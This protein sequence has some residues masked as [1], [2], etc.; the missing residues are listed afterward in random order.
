MLSW[1]PQLAVHTAKVNLFEDET[2]M[3]SAKLYDIVEVFK[4]TLSLSATQIANIL[5]D[6]DRSYLM[7]GR[8]ENFSVTYLCTS[9]SHIIAEF[10]VKKWD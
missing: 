5:R 10:F 3:I 2:K 7:K 1:V 4:T 8:L 6:V 9:R